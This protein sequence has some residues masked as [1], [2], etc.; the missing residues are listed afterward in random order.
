MQTIDLNLIEEMAQTMYCD[1]YTQ[2]GTCTPQKW[3]MT[4]ETQREFFRG[5]AA[6]VLNMLRLKGLLV[7]K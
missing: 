4:S 2:Y 7:T 5:Q 1:S 6:A 3:K